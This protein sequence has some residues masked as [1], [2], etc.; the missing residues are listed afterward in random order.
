MTVDKDLKKTEVTET[1][2]TINTETSETVAKKTAAKK[3]TTVEITEKLAEV[4]TKTFAGQRL[5][6]AFMRFR[7][8]AHE[9]LQN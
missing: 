2:E 3:K 4:I 8:L 7:D 5:P 6:A 9:N 1:T